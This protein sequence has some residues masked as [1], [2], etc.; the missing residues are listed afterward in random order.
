MILYMI[1]T[2]K[3]FFFL[4]LSISCA[5]TNSIYRGKDILGAEEFVIDSYQILENESHQNTIVYSIKDLSPQKKVTICADKKNLWEALSLVSKKAH[6][7]YLIRNSQLLPID[8]HSL[9]ENQDEKQNIVLKRDDKIYVME[10]SYIM[11]LGDVAK[12]CFIDVS[13]GYIPLRQALIHAE[14]ISSSGNRAYIQIFR[15]NILQPKIY[16]LHLKYVTN[17]P[18]HSMLLIPGDIICV[19]TKPSA[20][21]SFAINELSPNFMTFDLLRK[22]TSLEVIIE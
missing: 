3:L 9:M 10:N 2:I 13:H 11:M 15:G 17:L 5:C 19:T 6:L 21:W 22:K 7:S 8:L 4:F 1:K 16:I 20:G 12:E 18:E 14:G